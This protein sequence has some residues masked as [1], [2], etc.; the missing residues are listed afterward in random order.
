MPSAGAASAASRA[1]IPLA[2]IE[3]QW[4]RMGKEDQAAVF[5][6]LEEL[7]KKNWKEL[8]LAEKKAAYY[9]NFGPHGPRKPVNP[10]GTT[11]QVTAGVVGLL[12]V[13]GAL[14]AVIRSFADPAPKTMTKEWQEASNERAKEMNLNPISGISS[15][16]YKGKGFVQSK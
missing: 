3:A 15:E 13:T 8:S 10:P 1:A 7:Q 11:M 12:A 6:Q 16:D 5:E 2:N 4:E 9:V 14:W